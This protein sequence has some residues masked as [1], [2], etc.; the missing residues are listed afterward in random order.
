[1][2]TLIL[3]SIDNAM[4]WTNLFWSLEVSVETHHWIWACPPRAMKEGRRKEWQRKSG[5]D[6]PEYKPTDSLLCTV[7][8]NSSFRLPHYSRSTNVKPSRCASY[9]SCTFQIQTPFLSSSILLC[10]GRTD[11]HKPL[12]T[13]ACSLTALLKKQLEILGQK[14]STVLWFDS[15]YVPLPKAIRPTWQPSPRATAPTS[16]QELHLPIVPSGQGAVTAPDV[17]QQ[18][19]WASPN[20]I[21]RDVGPSLRSLNYPFGVCFI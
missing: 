7:F 2:S 10:S 20:P 5:E 13:L 4:K 16:F 6:S 11:L 1:M 17:L 12:N 14:Q 19:L 3:E 15:S 21:Q 9:S 18:P 8:V